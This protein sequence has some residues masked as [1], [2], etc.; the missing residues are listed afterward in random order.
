MSRAKKQQ[1]IEVVPPAEEP[2]EMP[3]P[4]DP[5]VLL[6][7]GLSALALLT[8]AYVAA[9]I[10]LPLVLAA[11]LNLLLQPA[12]RVLQRWHVP[13]ILAAL[14]QKALQRVDGVPARNSTA[15]ER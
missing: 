3:L 9:D 15:P 13:K 14:L 11:V 5:K 4:S 6:L 8:A 12:M 7:G 10:V 1:E 2:E